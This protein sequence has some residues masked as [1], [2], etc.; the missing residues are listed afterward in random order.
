VAVAVGSVLSGGSCCRGRQLLHRRHFVQ[1]VYNA[2]KE[3]DHHE[4][5][6]GNI[7]LGTVARSPR[8]DEPIGGS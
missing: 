5:A 2:G 6:V 8:P 3:A 4:A 1:R 7:E